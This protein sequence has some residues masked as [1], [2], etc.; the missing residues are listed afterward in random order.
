MR[1][2]FEFISKFEYKGNHIIDFWI[3][4]RAAKGHTLG[5]YICLFTEFIFKTKVLPLPQIFK[6]IIPNNGDCNFKD[7]YIA[8]LLLG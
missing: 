2:S 5:E 6:T 3:I 4:R 7:A 8:S 1:H